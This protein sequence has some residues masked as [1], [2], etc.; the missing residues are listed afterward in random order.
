MIW[1]ELRTHET[2]YDEGWNFTQSVWAPTAKENGSKWP[3]WSSV[4]QVIKGDIIFHLRHFKGEKQFLGYST[5]AT[6]SYI[7]NKIP[8]QLAHGWDFS[9]MFYK[10]DLKDYQAFSTPVQLF[11]F[12]SDNELT[13]RTI[14]N[15]NKTDPA[16]K[17]LFYA[18]QRN[19]LQC[20]FGAYFSELD[21]RL[22]GLLVQGILQLNTN[23]TVSDRVETSEAMRNMKVRIGQQKFSENVKRNFEY[24]CC[25]PG[26]NVV[27]R[28]FLIGGHIDRWCDNMDLRGETANGIC[29]C[30]MH[31]KAFE[32]GYF[33]LDTEYKICLNPNS[34]R[35]AWLNEFLHSGLNMEIKPRRIDLSI[36]AIKRHQDRIKFA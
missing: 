3:F 27:G 2:Q 25:F 36:A 24:K 26:C 11:N 32:H 19:K 33:T 10:A 5:A 29:L 18:I 22:S 21:E 35:A 15:A 34:V 12:F 31:D 4:N 6:D 14:F 30:L 8:T 1:L 17:H 28:N 7:T 13:L 23:T 16:H 9:R 20:L